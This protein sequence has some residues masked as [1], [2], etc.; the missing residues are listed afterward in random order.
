MVLKHGGEAEYDEMLKVCLCIVSF[1]SVLYCYWQFRVS[2]AVEISWNLKSLL[3]ISWKFIDAPGKFE[4]GT[5]LNASWKSRNLSGW[6][7]R[8]PVLLKLMKT[9]DIQMFPSNIS[10][11]QD[12]QPLNDWTGVLNLLNLCSVII[13]CHWLCLSICL[14]FF[15][16]VSRSSHFLAISSAWQKLQNGVLRFLI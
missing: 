16:F 13:F 15:F 5:L 10:T 12:G 7:F 3:E 4:N 9:T 11:Q 8:H 2:S 6:I 1:L 14:C